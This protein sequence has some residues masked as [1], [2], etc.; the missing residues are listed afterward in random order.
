[1]E[2]R[3]HFPP[4]VTKRMRFYSNATVNEALADLVARHA[5]TL[6]LEKQERGE[7]GEGQRRL[8]MPGNDED[9][10]KDDGNDDGGGGGGGGGGDPSNVGSHGYGFFVPRWTN[11][12][13]SG[14][15]D[16]QATLH[17]QGLRAGDIVEC[18]PLQHRLT[19]LLPSSS[20][21]APASASPQASSPRAS[22]PPRSPR[23]GQAEGRLLRTKVSATLTVG[24]LL[25][26]LLRVWLPPSLPPSANRPMCSCLRG[27]CT[28]CCRCSLAGEKQCL[29]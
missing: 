13:V 27:M 28:W 4:M 26:I 21:S 15:L 16:S 1:M 19:L 18:R 17:E 20:S 25:P 8:Q 14:W 11:S 3:V 5:H 12:R 22:S 6:L 2:L 24:G 10:D 7:E 23:G 29:L 9:E